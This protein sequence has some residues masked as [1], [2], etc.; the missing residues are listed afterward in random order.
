[1]ESITGFVER[2]LKLKVNRTKS[3]VA[4]PWKRKFLGYTVTSEYKARLKPAPES[5]KRTKDR[6]R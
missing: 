6:I 4:R 3:T 1:M 5:V 2:K